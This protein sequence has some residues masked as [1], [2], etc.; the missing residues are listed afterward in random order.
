MSDPH[1][2]DD[3]RQQGDQGAPA[4]GPD[5]GSPWSGGY[6]QPDPNQPRYDQGQPQYGQTP[7]GQPQYGQPQYGQPQYGQSPAYGQPP[8]GASPYGQP[9]A[10]QPGPY[11]G[12]SQPQYG[13]QSYGDPQYGQPYGQPGQEQQPY[14]QPAYGAP[15]QQ[16]YAQTSAGAPTAP[17]QDQFAGMNRPLRD[18]KPFRIAVVGGVVAIVVIVLAITAFVAPG[19]AV[20]KELNQSA[21]QDGVK[22]IL[23][24][25]YQATEVGGVS[26]PDGQKVEKGKSFDC[27]ATV[28]GAQQK[29]TITFLDDN[30]RYEV[31][32]PT[33]N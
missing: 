23:E 24:K 1:N 11:T 8:T 19:F 18:R 4:G 7:Y 22:S 10:E 12:P 16:Q 17:G 2:P 26:C 6:Q 33:A 14:G 20:N 28:A 27:T 15:G 32:R 30:G 29:V 25:D 3:P 31:G 21:V 5:A 9:G 13:Q